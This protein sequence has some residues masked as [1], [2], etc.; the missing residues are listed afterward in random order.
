MHTSILKTLQ[1]CVDERRKDPRQQHQLK[2]EWWDKMVPCFL[3]ASS[4]GSLDAVKYFIDSGKEPNIRYIIKQH[5]HALCFISKQG[6][7]CPLY[8]TH[9]H[10]QKLFSPVDCCPAMQLHGQFECSL[11]ILDT[12]DQDRGRLIPS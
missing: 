9:G 12:T 3:H 11:A 10:V 7:K 6:I 2:T 8:I 4:C 5:L 1:T